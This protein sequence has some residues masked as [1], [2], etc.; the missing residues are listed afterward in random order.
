MGE[1]K[2]EKV[3]K[4]KEKKMKQKPVEATKKQEEE[5]KVTEKTEQ[6][7]RE[8]K[9]ERWQK[10]CLEAMDKDEVVKTLQL[11]L[12]S[13]KKGTKKSL[14]DDEDKKEIHLQFAVKRIPNVKN[15]ILKL[16]LPHS[17]WTSEQ[18]VCLIVKDID[19]S[20]R[21]HEVTEQHYKD[22]LSSKGITCITQIIPLKSLKLEY[23]PFEA[24]RNLANMFDLFVA[25]ERI[26]RLLPTLLGRNFYGKKKHPIQVNM[27]ATNLKNEIEKVVFGSRC[28]ITG[29][30][31]SSTSTI[32]HSDMSA[33]QLAENVMKALESISG[34]LPG[35]ASN[36][37]SVYVRTDKSL[38]LPLYATF[39]SKKEVKL[40]KKPEKPAPVMGE[41]STLMDG[42]VL[43]TNMGQVKVGK[44]DEKGQFTTMRRKK[45]PERKTKRKMEEESDDEMHFEEVEKK[46]R[47]TNSKDNKNKTLDNQTDDNVDSVS[48]MDIT[49]TDEGEP[50][51]E[52]VKS[53]KVTSKK[54]KKEEME[55]VSTK[56]AKN[57]GG[58]KSLVK[59]SKL[60]TSKKGKGITT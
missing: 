6:K 44:L 39:T 14:L 47:K 51:V 45:I 55:N 56:T 4:I 23:K 20:S 59:K 50:A 18:E 49:V 60:K 19:K 1:M 5:S 54:G 52:K 31:A 43:V 16:R 21:E 26:V 46:K 53:V 35:G 42:H 15:K 40:P 57:K 3:T 37:Q 27:T 17:V 10:T 7:T 9:T 29:H 2:K 28:I 22:L 34:A 12:Q 41:I 13:V 11:L 8:T 58:E 32:G 38:A 24:K 25:D 30:G 33:E 36:I 48:R